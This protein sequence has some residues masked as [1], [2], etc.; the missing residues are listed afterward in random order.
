MYIGEVNLWAYK[1]NVYIEN[2][3]PDRKSRVHESNMFKYLFE[4]YIQ[5]LKSSVHMHD[6]YESKIIAT[7]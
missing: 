6:I 1:N 4:A 2:Q 3:I 5:V 7:F